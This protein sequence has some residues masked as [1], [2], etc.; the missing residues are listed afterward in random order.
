ML[1]RR[2]ISHVDNRY[3]RV[4]EIVMIIA[5]YCVRRTHSADAIITISV[6]CQWPI[7]LSGM[8]AIPHILR[9]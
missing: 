4:A 3:A 6:L 5:G 1:N 9:V 2:Q 8:S 7:L